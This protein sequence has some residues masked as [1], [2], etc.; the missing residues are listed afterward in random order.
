MEKQ[1][2][3]LDLESVKNNRFH[4][5]RKEIAAFSERY[6]EDINDD[7]QWDEAAYRYAQEQGWKDSWKEYKAW[8]SFMN[9]V[10][11]NGQLVD[12]FD[13]KIG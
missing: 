13:G 11:M 3:P 6:T 5:Y 7:I 1:L 8:L 9:D 10:K 2:K 12:Y 4:I